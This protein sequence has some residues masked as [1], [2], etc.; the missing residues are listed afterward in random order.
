MPRLTITPQYPTEIFTATYLPTNTPFFV[1]PTPTFVGPTPLW[2]LLEATYTPTPLYVNTP[3]PISEAFRA[4]LRAFHS[5]NFTEMLH[6]MEQATREETQSAD[7]HYYLGESLR[8]LE[9]PEQARVAYEQAILINP[10]F[11]PAYLGRA[12]TNILLQEFD[13]VQYDLEKAIDTD[14]NLVEAYLEYAGFKLHAGEPENALDLLSYVEKIAPESPLLHQ[15][16]AET[17]IDFGDYESA[18]IAAEE[19]YELDRTSLPIYAILGQAHL[20][21][22]N[23]VKAKEFL[24]IYLSFEEDEGN[25]LAALGQTQFELG[26]FA[27]SVE[28][29]T[30]ALQVQEGFFPALLYRGLGYLELNEGQAAVNDL[31]SARNLARESFEA[32]LGLA[33]ALAVTE[34]LD[35]AISQFAMSEELAENDSQLAEVYYW[36]A[37]SREVNGELRIAAQDW[38]A[39]ASLPIGSVSPDWLALAQEKL[40]IL[41]PSPTIT[42]TTLPTS[43]PTKPDILFIP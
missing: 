16:R 21:N 5:G 36:R 35:D 38:I 40:I 20:A 9:E 22:G 7:A 13:N 6:Y 34:R 8:F 41:T 25:A 33:R 29:L 4:G 11:A 14:P 27:R 10:E 30:H 23:L 15:L 17:Y 43:T 3:H 19:A 24:Q 26:E 42:P 32:S 18:L 39:L 2:M 12:R 31:F 1:T 37:I 28:T